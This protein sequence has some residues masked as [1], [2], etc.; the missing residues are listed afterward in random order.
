MPIRCGAEAVDD[1]DPGS[2]DHGAMLTDIEAGADESEGAHLPA[3]AKKIAIG[4]GRT[5]VA[6]K[7]GV[8]QVEVRRQVGRGGVGGGLRVECRAQPPP[9][10]GQLSPVGLVRRPRGEC[11]RIIRK[12]FLIVLDRGR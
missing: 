8:Q 11:L 3:Q 10:E 4:N 5:A 1:L 12:L 6:P 7:A 9:D 2:A